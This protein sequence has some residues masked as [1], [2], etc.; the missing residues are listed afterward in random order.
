[1]I[2]KKQPEDFQPRFEIVSCYLEYEGK[3]VLLHRHLHKSQGGKWGVV[4]GKV[5][6]N[7]T[8]GEAMV[9]ELKEETGFA[10]SAEQLEYFTKVYVRHGGYDFVYHMFRLELDHQ[11]EIRTNPR[12][13]VAFKWVT[14]SEALKM[15][16]VEDLD[17]VIKLFYKV[18]A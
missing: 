4:A 2:F 6:E 14:P 12:E 8:P 13:H 11:P 3:F 10:A 9:R 5:E 7:E 18:P 16:F 17:T 1:M 15:N